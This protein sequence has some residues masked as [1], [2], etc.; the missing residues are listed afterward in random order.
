MLA[1][2]MRRI[3]DTA[4]SDLTIRRI[5]QGFSRILKDI[6]SAAARGLY[7]ANTDYL[8]YEESKDY[9]NRLCELGYTV[10]MLASSIPS[11]QD[12]LLYILIIKWGEDEL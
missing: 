8:G 9:S 5:D 7:E 4:N 1:S 3:A 6:E 12:P 10:D 11:R 2:E